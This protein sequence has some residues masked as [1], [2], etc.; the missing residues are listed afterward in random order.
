VLSSPAAHP[1]T[2]TAEQGWG[3]AQGHALLM[4]IEK[5]LPNHPHVAFYLGIVT[6]AAVRLLPRCRCLLQQLS[7]DPFSS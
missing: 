4:E 1:T 7:S 6:S 3:T 2:H 5:A